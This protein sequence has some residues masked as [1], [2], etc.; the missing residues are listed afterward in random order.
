MIR[1]S[2]LNQAIESKK[3]NLAKKAPGLKRDARASLPDLSAFALIVSGITRCGKS[4]LLFQLLKAGH[5]DALYLN[6]ENPRPYEVGPTDFTR[7]DASIK[8]SGS[9]VLFLT[10]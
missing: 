10:G 1:Q 4:T 3:A 6:F 2:S 7:L 8:A 9:K 5:P